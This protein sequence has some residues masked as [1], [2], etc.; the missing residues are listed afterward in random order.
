MKPSPATWQAHEAPDYDRTMKAKCDNLLNDIISSPARR[1]AVLDDPRVIHC[2]LFAS[3]VPAG[4]VEYAGTYRG[5]TGTTLVARVLESSSQLKPGT[6]YPFCSS[7]EVPERMK[8]LIE[9]ISEALKSDRASDYQQLLTL[10]YIFCWFGKIHPFL[11]GN[12]H[13]QR[14]IFAAMATEFGY[15][16]SVR[17]SIHP[18][19]YGPLMAVALELFTADSDDWEDDDFS[20]VGEY[21][22]FFLEGPFSAPLMHISKASP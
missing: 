4:F 5:S 1:R 8:Q 15:P 10:A 3:Y 2:E 6:S 17:F 13:V 20:V 12:G 21:L 18:R 14:A 19:P 7:G 11:D 9:I 16:L 22:G